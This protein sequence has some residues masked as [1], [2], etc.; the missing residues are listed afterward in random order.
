MSDQFTLT[1]EVAPVSVLRT[2]PPGH[3]SVLAIPVMMLLASCAGEKPAPVKGVWDFQPEKVWEV[4]EAGGMALRQPA[5][6][7]VSDDGRLYFHDFGLKISFIL[8]ERGRTVGR[9]A[10]PGTG[11][12]KVSRYM[13]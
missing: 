5:E 8:D 6:P 11:P 13:N 3:M 7:R 1:A 4:G 9:F 2:K 12:G 10:E